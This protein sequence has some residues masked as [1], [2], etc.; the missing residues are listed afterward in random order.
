[1]F[2]LLGKIMGGIIKIG[3]FCIQIFQIVISLITILFN[4]IENP[5]QF[6]LFLGQIFF[7]CFL[8]VFY[9][10]WKIAFRNFVFI[11]AILALHTVLTCC[12]IV[13]YCIFIVICLLFDT[14]IFRGW[15]YP[16]YYRMFGA[17][18][19]SPNSWYE[20]YG[21]QRRNINEGNSL[22]CRDNYTPD[23]NNSFMCSRLPSYEPRFCPEPL[24]YRLHK[25]KPDTKLFSGKEFIPSRDMYKNGN[26]EKKRELSEYLINTMEYTDSCKVYMKKYTSLTQSICKSLDMSSKSSHAQTL[27]DICY[28]SYCINGEWG[29]FC[30]KLDVDFEGNDAPADLESSAPSHVYMKLYFNC[31]FVGLMIL[32]C[33][34]ILS[35]NNKIL[36]T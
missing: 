24:V 34:I 13:L 7:A 15:I 33:H 8:F 30:H 35:K 2:D 4:S 9:I 22:R 28:K 32:I 10:L 18:E 20:N 25:N 29:N 3:E 16:I 36:N 19:N 14:V 5:F 11:P 1:M 12:L 6:I 27:R 31:I 26:T 21:Y 17:S 23:K